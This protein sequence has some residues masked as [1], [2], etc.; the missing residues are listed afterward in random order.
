MAPEWILRV[1]TSERA[2]GTGGREWGFEGPA[3][4]GQFHWWNRAVQEEE[5]GFIFGLRYFGAIGI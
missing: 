1:P 2:L 3:H 5:R 4:T